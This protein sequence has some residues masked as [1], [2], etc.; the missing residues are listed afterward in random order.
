MTQ[1]PDT[2]P[3]YDRLEQAAEAGAR[4]ALEKVGLHDEHAGRDIAEIRSL[5][6]AWREAKT[7]VRG[8]VIKWVTVAVLTIIAASL[9]FR[10][11]SP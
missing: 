11:L 7:T 5:L 10:H 1:H 9:G 4:R 2:P 8:A 3:E 6:E